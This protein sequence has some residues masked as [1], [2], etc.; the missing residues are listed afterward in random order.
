MTHYNVYSEISVKM[1]GFY[2]NIVSKSLAFLCNRIRRGVSGVG[3]IERLDGD[4]ILG[5]I[6]SEGIYALHET[7]LFGPPLRVTFRRT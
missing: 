5:H 2:S 7:Q 6:T 1:D 3:T 4:S